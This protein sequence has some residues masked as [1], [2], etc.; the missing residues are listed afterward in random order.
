MFLLAH[1]DHAR[2]IA[3]L[4]VRDEG[5]G[6]E[7]LRVILARAVEFFDDGGRQRRQGLVFPVRHGTEKDHAVLIGQHDLVRALHPAFFQGFQVHLDRCQAQHVA[8]LV[9][10][11]GK[12]VAGF[13]PRRADAIKTP[14]RA[15]QGVL[16]VGAERDIVANKAVGLLPIAGGTR[17]AVEVAD[18]NGRRF[19]LGIHLLQV[20]V[21]RIDQ[22]RVFRMLQQADHVAVQFQRLGQEIVFFQR[23]FQAA[24]IH[25]E[26]LRATRLQLAD[27]DAFGPEIH[28]PD[29]RQ[30]RCQHHAPGQRFTAGALRQTLAPGKGGFVTAIHKIS[31]QLAR[32]H[33]IA[34]KYCVKRK[35]R[36][37]CIRRLT[38]LCHGQLDVLR[39]CGACP[40]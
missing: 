16:G 15:P 21:D 20:M 19:R 31:C 38:L 9:D 23:V 18:E 39:T 5:D 12:E 8:I 24:D 11:M 10:A 22:H 32:T 27:G 2:A 37:I 17:V 28:E 7:L 36:R 26:A 13:E 6:F 14:R 4:A 3:Q 34:F 30:A 25:L 40:G 1:A 35:S 33:S 29:G